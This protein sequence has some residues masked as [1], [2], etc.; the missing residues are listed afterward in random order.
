MSIDAM[1]RDF[2]MGSLRKRDANADPIE[3]F[4]KWFDEALTANKGE[5]FE[6]NAM[7]LATVDPSGM[8]DARIVLMKSFDQRG[9]VFYTNYR[10]TKGQQLEEHPYATLVF[11][12]PAL[13][14]Q[15]KIL[16]GVSKVSEEQS[17]EY[18]LSRPKGSQLG[19]MA[20]EQSKPIA[21]RKVLESELETLEDLFADREIERPEEWG[22]Y[23]VKPV[24]I[25]F[26]QGRTNRLHDRLLYSQDEQGAWSIQRISP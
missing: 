18:F 17:D 5:W 15:V 9:F 14:R 12:W 7:T 26:W 8:P 23:C 19:A 22:G 20:S 13:E 11:Y 10:S 16:G 3:Q 2:D 24:K 1:R 6:P 25:E 4:R 21:N